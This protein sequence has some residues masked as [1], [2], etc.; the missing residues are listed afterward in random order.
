MG[1]SGALPPPPKGG[2]PK[3]FAKQRGVHNRLVSGPAALR[4]CFLYWKLSQA[5]LRF[6]P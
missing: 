6:A 2:S 1:S 3:V 5:G 4:P